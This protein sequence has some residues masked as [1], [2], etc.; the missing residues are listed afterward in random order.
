MRNG[1][2]PH[3]RGPFTASGSG[4]GSGLVLDLLVGATGRLEARGLGGL[5]VREP[6][7]GVGLVVPLRTLDVVLPGV[8]VALDGVALGGRAV[9]GRGDGTGGELDRGRLVL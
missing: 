9:L 7:L 1:P 5:G 8:G 2:L 6:E 3:G 4:R